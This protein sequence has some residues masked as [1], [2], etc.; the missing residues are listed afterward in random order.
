M[1]EKAAGKHGASSAAAVAAGPLTVSRPELISEAMPWPPLR[2]S[3]VVMD[4][5][6]DSR[7]IVRRTWDRG[8]EGTENRHNCIVPG[9]NQLGDRGLCREVLG[10]H[11]RLGLQKTN[12]DAQLVLMAR[13]WRR[14]RW[15][16]G[17]LWLAWQAGACRSSL[18]ERGSPLAASTA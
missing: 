17:V 1:R 12:V 14:R 4:F 2:V 3:S 10:V 8:G 5:L 18:S 7:W 16:G 6:R 15:W 11:A 9:H 13:R